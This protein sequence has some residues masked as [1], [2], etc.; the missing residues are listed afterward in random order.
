MSS[1]LKIIHI[2]NDLKFVRTDEVFCCE[3]VNNFSIFIGNSKTVPKPGLLMFTYSS[4]D[5]NSIINLCKDADGV[6][7]YS[8][9]Y[10]KAYIVNRLPKSVIVFW[11]FFGGELYEKLPG[12]VFSEGTQRILQSKSHHSYISY[13]NK[14]LR[15]GFWRLKYHSS[16]NRELNKAMFSRTDYFLTLVDYEYKFLKSK[17]PQLPPLLE[18]PRQSKLMVQSTKKRN[19]RC[20]ILLGNNRSPY[21]NHFELLEQISG[22]DKI[23]GFQ[24]VLMFNYGRKDYYYSQI[25]KMAEGISNVTILEEYL[26]LSDLYNLYEEAAAIVL[27][28]YRQMG[29]ANLYIAL[30]KDVKIYLHKNNILYQWMLDNGFRIFNIYDFPEDWENEEINLSQE[31]AIHNHMQLK[32]LIGEDNSAIFCHMIKGLFK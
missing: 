20:K 30:N 31:D 2:H 32:E 22:L 4:N 19:N 18:L 24:Y 10:I 13:W 27:N 3:C 11:R 5:V 26:S 9:D 25:K 8:L 29:L 17:F 15:K 1:Q 6:V 16:P 21:N 23:P 14:T 7:I 28:G 12:Y